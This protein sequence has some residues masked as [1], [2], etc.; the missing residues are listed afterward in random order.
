MPR[1]GRRVGAGRKKGQKDLVPRVP[2]KPL[3]MSSAGRDA[4]EQIANFML[5]HGTAWLE[6]V[7]ARARAKDDLNL[8]ASLLT[9]CWGRTFGNQPLHQPE[10]VNAF[11]LAKRLYDE[12]KKR[13]ALT[14]EVVEQKRLPASRDEE[15]AMEVEEERRRSRE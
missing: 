11:D 13:E 1:G 5:S 9:F 3:G 7:I 15:I 2:R 6:D 10:P 4:R 14:T 8:E 12:K